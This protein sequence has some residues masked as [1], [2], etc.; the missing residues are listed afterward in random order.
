MCLSFF[1]SSNYHWSSF[2]FCLLSVC[3][4]TLDWMDVIRSSF[5][6]CLSVRLFVCLSEWV[7]ERSILEWI[8][9]NINKN[10][11]FFSLFSHQIDFYWHLEFKFELINSV[12]SSKQQNERWFGLIT[13]VMSA[14]VSLSF[15]IGPTDLSNEN[16]NMFSLLLLLCSCFFLFSFHQLNFI[17]LVFKWRRYLRQQIPIRFYLRKIFF[18]NSFRMEKLM[19]SSK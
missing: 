14:F 15:L 18:W 6:F 11:S 1:R 9:E 8:W 7:S 3:F 4:L 2:V 12:N 5:V 19:K 16:E 10:F 13:M 17:E